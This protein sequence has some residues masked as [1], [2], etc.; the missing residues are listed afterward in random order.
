M[1]ETITNKIHHQ[2]TSTPVIL[3]MKGCPLFPQCGF[4]SQVAHIL[5]SLKINFQYVNILSHPEIRSHLPHYAQWPTFPQL[6]LKG[7]L[8]GG[9][10]IVTE[11][12]QSG[13][14]EELFKKESIEQNA[15]IEAC[16]I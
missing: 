9:C 1:S 3:Y 7:E 11:L 16:L 4:S 14:L 2:I 10:D 5:Q 13:E 8:I 12:F 6:W 15:H